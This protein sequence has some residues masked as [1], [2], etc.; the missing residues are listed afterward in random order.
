MKHVSLNLLAV[1]LLIVAVLGMYLMPRANYDVILG[2]QEE[3]RR[4]LED[5]R[6]K[7]ETYRQAAK[8]VLASVPVATE[9]IN[10]L[11]EILRNC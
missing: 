3:N 2:Q 11:F 7:T 5:L 4:N 1:G 9:E 6:Q 8:T 10:R